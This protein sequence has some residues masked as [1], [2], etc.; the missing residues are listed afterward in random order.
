MHE[1]DPAA[2]M[3]LE[4]ALAMAEPV[5]FVQ[6]F[7]EDSLAL[8]SVGRLGDSGVTAT[9]GAVQPILASERSNAVAVPSQTSAGSV[10]VGE[11]TDRELSVLRMLASRLS[12]KEIA[13]ELYVSVNTVKSHVKSIYLKLDVSTRNDAVARATSLR[14]R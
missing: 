3:S 1:G 13:H 8:S 10:L 7:I 4:I 12:N 6:T 9:V 5:G 11:L 14:L 2:A